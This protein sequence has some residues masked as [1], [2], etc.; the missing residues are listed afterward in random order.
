MKSIL[1]RTAL[2]FVLGAAA[3]GVLLATSPAH[4]VDPVP[5]STARYDRDGNATPFGP[6]PVYGPRSPGAVFGEPRVVGVVEQPYIVTRTYQPVIVAPSYQPRVVARSAPVIVQPNTVYAPRVV[7]RG[8]YV[9][10]TPAVVYPAAP[11]GAAD[12]LR[13]ADALDDITPAAGPNAA[14]ARAEFELMDKN[15][16]GSISGDEYV[17]YAKRYGDPRYWNY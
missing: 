16:D 10:E 17:Y 11:L 2:T 15:N 4:A 7:S 3:A 8:Y 9:Y 6:L 13:V 14:A 5:P 1:G 12:S